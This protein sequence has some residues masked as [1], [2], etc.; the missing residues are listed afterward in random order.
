MRSEL[1]WHTNAKEMTEMDET[2][3]DGSTRVNRNEGSPLSS[4]GIAGPRTMTVPTMRTMDT[5]ATALAL[6]RFSMSR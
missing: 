5:S 1:W 2:M 6:E 3:C 4:A